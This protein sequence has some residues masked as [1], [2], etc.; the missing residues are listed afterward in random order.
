M[1]KDV[2]TPTSDFVDVSIT[3]IPILLQ[4]QYR[5]RLSSEARFQYF[6]GRRQRPTPTVQITAT[7]LIV[8]AT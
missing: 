5:S 6:P 8:G 3:S 1:A 4:M 7:L 2:L